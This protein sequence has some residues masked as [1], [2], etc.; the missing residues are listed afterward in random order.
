M[1]RLLLFL[2]SAILAIL[3]Q[4][5]QLPWYTVA[6]LVLPLAVFLPMRKFAGFSMAFWGTFVIWAGLA[7][8]YHM[9]NEGLL[10]DRLAGTF[11]L[12]SGWWL[13]IITG[14][15]GGLSSGLAGWTGVALRAA[16][17]P[18]PSKA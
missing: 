1:N 8:Y 3:T 17:R 10:G 13:V 6:L 18:R 15:W 4:L 7:V 2:G 5:L 14:C 12:N 11:G 16:L 9:T